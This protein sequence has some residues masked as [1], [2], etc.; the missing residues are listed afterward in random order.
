MNTKVFKY[1]LDFSGNI[2]QINKD[3][4]GL[5]GML[6]GAAAA[7]GAMFAVDKAMA[8]AAAVYAYANEISNTR[9]EV[10]KL[11]GAHGSALD[12]MTGQ[13]TAIAQAYDVEVNESIR[14]SSLLMT[15]FG[16]N[17]QEA[18][19]I[20]NAG[21]ASAANSNGDFLEQVSEYAPHFKEAGLAASEMVAIIA[22]GNKMGVFND[23]T[24]D[25][26]KEGTI[27][28]R[29]MT[30]GTKDA[31]NAIGLSSSQIQKD[32]SSG[33]KSMF[34]VMQEVSRQLKLLPQQSPA[35]G[36][37]L[38]DIFGGPGEDAV[39]FIRALGDIDTNLDNVLSQSGE[40]AR[41]QI[42]WTEALA[43]FHTTGAQAFGGTGN[44]ILQ[45]RTTMLN[46][47]NDG[48]KGMV[49]I[50]NYFI[51][52]YNESTAF[53]YV[54]EAIK[55]NF[56][57][58][59][60]TVSAALGLIW[61]NLKATGKFLKAV[62][63]FD[64]EGI[65]EAW[66]SGF[67]GVADVVSNYGKET[68]KNYTDAWNNTLSPKKKVELIS[69]SSE[70]AQAAGEVTGT[71]YGKG[72]AKAMAMV[73]VNESGVQKSLSQ[74]VDEALSMDN[75]SMDKSM[76][77]EIDDAFNN[78]GKDMKTPEA[79][80]TFGKDWADTLEAAKARTEAFNGA[81]QTGFAAIGASIV[82]GLGLAED[83]FEG[84]LGGL[85]DT[86]VSLLSMM[87][88]QSIANAIAGATASGAA[89]G[90]AA[91]FTTPAF[92]ATAV[93]GVLAA[94]AA[95]PKFATGGVVGGSSFSGDNVLVR[96]N[97]GEEILRRND[98]R[99]VLNANGSSVTA[100]VQQVRVMIPRTRIRK[101]DIYIAYEEGK[102]EYQKRNG[103]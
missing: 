94:F 36:Q 68:V 75:W 78:I 23:K 93:G 39:Q 77:K 65:K 91:I 90:P 22:E 74:Q 48:I 76:F 87:M 54:V 19:A 96:V 71:N 21:M 14:A 45:I 103:R 2:Q 17:S 85:L 9:S 25:A 7:A 18:F 46:W 58:L 70:A 50:I 6:K 64:I 40:A 83:G 84:F 57:Q 62:F 3:I 86:T 32:I 61:E 51:D 16:A 20:I 5:N 88:A 80:E 49:G 15:Q 42:E 100:A 59:G 89:T 55:L 33:N 13:A 10:E 35:V 95:I 79:I 26:I 4:G 8:A 102:K 67:K 98:P 63:T 27:R 82:S 66:T 30:Q 24:A 47:L 43:E 44:M 53:R 99:N 31:I 69:L 56:K 52:L 72:F 60:S 41:A 73:K 1:I 38:A 29:E 11:T 12:T 34:D 92:I 28:L 101:G 81:M 37:A 97:S